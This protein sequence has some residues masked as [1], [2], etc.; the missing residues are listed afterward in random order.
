LEDE[1]RPGGGIAWLTRRLHGRTVVEMLTLNPAPGVLP[2][3][4]PDMITVR[5]SASGG[6]PPYRFAI[7]GVGLP[8]GV[9]L[10][11]DGLLSGGIVQAAE[12]EAMYACNV[13]A[14]VLVT[15]S[16]GNCVRGVYYLPLR[17][18]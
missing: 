14:L 16:A 11:P 15:D 4:R 12:P 17:L 5:L 7:S 10:T 9:T 3:M 13:T 18:Q 8:W 2:Q 6:M 1:A